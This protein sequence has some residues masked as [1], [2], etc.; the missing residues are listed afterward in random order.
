L[1][2]RCELLS[3]QLAQMLARGA[4]LERRLGRGSSTT[5]KPPSSDPPFAKPAPKRSARMRSGRRPG[6]QDE[7]PGS[8][9]ER[10]EDP[11]RIVC[12]DPVTCGG[13]GDCLLGA[14][15]FDERAHQ[16]FDVPPPPSRV[17]VTEYRVSRTCSG[18]GTT[19]VRDIPAWARGR[20][21]YGPTLT[22]WAG[23]LVCAHRL[24]VR[25]AA[26]VLP[27]LLGAQVSTGWVAARRAQAARPL[28]GSILP[29]VRKLVASAPVAHEDETCAR[30][31]GAVR[32][33][34]VACTEYLTATHVGKGVGEAIDA[35][36]V[37]LAFDGVLVRD[38]YTGYAHLDNVLHAWCGAHLLREGDPEERLWAAAMATTSSAAN[39]T[40]HAA[41]AARRDALTPHAPA[42]IRSRHLGALSRGRD[43]NLGK[44][45]LP[46]KEVRTL[47]RRFEAHED[48]IL[49]CGVKVQ[50]R[51][52]GG[53][54]RTLRGLIDVAVVQFH[55]GSGLP[56]HSATPQ[57]Q[58]DD[59]SP[60]LNS[61]L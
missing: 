58:P 17:K 35:G 29:R 14:P 6:K 18:C 57:P 11:D 46:A 4:E 30:A 26:L 2:G 7:T 36:G 42:A 24:P 47:I 37:R 32:C 12:R 60:Q 39:K 8:A 43:D 40:A 44:Q 23:W 20:V 13:C 55:R 61:Y 10:V 5:S 54:R 15:V 48:V 33:L 34:H 3:T 27:A 45:R 19:A 59:P 9:L 52:S 21:Q 28:A 25:R 49:H 22:A 51:T 38:G 16:L 56:S 41:I 31:Q 1:S 50:R 53:C